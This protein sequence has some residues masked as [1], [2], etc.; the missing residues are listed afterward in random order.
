M[1]FLCVG[2]TVAGL[3]ASLVLPFLP[4]A[5]ALLLATVLG[6]ASRVWNGDSFG[7]TLLY[8][9]VLLVLTQ[10]GYGMGVLGRAALRII[11]QAAARGRSVKGNALHS[12][13]LQPRAG[14]D[15]P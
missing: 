14:R 2:A 13:G 6:I 15:Q 1:T 10:L 12:N 3:L 8:G 7:Q 5:S 9:F 11:S 4:L